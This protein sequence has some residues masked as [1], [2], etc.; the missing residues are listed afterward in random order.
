MNL[1]SLSIALLLAGI[2]LPKFQGPGVLFLFAQTPTPSGTGKLRI[3]DVPDPVE[4]LVQDPAEREE[5]QQIEKSEDPNQRTLLIEEFVKKYAES[6]Y[7]GQVHHMATLDY[8]R[9][10]QAEKM[11]VHGQKT[12]GLLPDN[13]PILNLMALVYSNKENPDRAIELAMR[14]LGRLEKIVP[15][16]NTDQKQW[17]SEYRRYMAQSLAGLGNAYLAK[18]EIEQ[19]VLKKAVPQEGTAPGIPTAKSSKLATL[20]LARAYG[21]LTKSLKEEPRSQFV[22]FQLGVVSTR[23]KRYRQAINAFARASLLDGNYQD[24]SR[25]NLESLYRLIHQDS[26]DGLQGLLGEARADLAIANGKLDPVNNNP[27]TTRSD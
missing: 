22:H 7:L 9:L 5:F 8:Q 19:K 14:A 26:L 2:C 3:Y 20:H 4:E 16:A 12:L 6:A 13:I 17:E 27:T 24:I 23:L 15:P 11:F 10:N 18:Y 1:R 25:R 21:Y